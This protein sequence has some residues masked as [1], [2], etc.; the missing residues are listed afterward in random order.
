[1]KNLMCSMLGFAC[2]GLGAMGVVLPLVPTTPLVLLAAL[3]FS[4]SNQKMADWLKRSPF[5]GPFIEHYHT[6]RGVKK[7]LKKTSIAILWA[8]L[9]LSMISMRTA[10]VC[11]LLL[12][13]G[14]CVTV[15]ILM[16]KTAD[17]PEGAYT[18]PPPACRR[19]GQ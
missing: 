8:G 17:C 10:W 14:G 19:S 5:F 1:M 11:A 2:L 15:H 12:I 9:V 13:V 16:I 3:C 18:S 6:K 4:K 7:S